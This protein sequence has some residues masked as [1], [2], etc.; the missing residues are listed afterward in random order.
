MNAA[1]LYLIKQAGPHK[2]VGDTIIM[3]PATMLKP[4]RPFAPIGAALMAGGL[5]LGLYRWLKPKPKPQQQP[6]PQQAGMY[7][8]QGMMHPQQYAQ[9]YQQQVGGR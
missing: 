7:P 9:M 5:G 2:V 6:Q 8:Q 1:R 4:V 3:D